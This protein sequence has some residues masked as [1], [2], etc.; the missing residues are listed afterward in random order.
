VKCKLKIIQDLKQS[1]VRPH[2]EYSLPVWNPHYRKDKLLA[3]IGESTT[4]FYQVV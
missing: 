2:L 3:V 4:P 1:L